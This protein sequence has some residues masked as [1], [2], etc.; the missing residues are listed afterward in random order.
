MS[1]PVTAS[2]GTASASKEAILTLLGVS[3]HLC[4]HSDHSLHIS[5]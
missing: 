2:S 4:D 1:T 5:Y 3:P